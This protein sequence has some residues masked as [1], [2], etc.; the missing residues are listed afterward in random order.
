MKQKLSATM[1][2]PV[3][4]S[5][6]IHHW[7]IEPATGPLSRGVCKLCGEQKEFFNILDDFQ[8]NEEIYIHIEDKDSTLLGVDNED[9]V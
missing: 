8:T 5:N 2:R 9:G 1:S 7:L 6:C 4:K 3:K